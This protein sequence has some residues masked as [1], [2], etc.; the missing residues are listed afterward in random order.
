MPFIP[1]HPLQIL[2]L[3]YRAANMLSDV[4]AAPALAWL[5]ADMRRGVLETTMAVGKAAASPI[6]CEHS[7]L[8]RCGC[9]ARCGRKAGTWRAVPA[10]TRACLA[11]GV[12]P[13]AHP[14]LARALLAAAPAGGRVPRAW[15]EPAMRLTCAVHAAPGSE[16]PAGGCAST[17]LTRCLSGARRCACSSQ[18]KTWATC[19]PRAQASRAPAALT[20]A[21]RAQ[22]PALCMPSCPRRA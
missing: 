13:G 20:P 4:L 1:T 3:D 14:A 7:W 18:K 10:F 16:L 2:G 19:T 22:L 8:P 15:E 9:H 11:A 21:V 12:C 17:S 5:P 6:R